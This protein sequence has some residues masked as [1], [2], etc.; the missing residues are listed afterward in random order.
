MNNALKGFMDSIKLKNTRTESILANIKKTITD[1][2]DSRGNIN[3]NIENLI[4]TGK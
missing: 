2:L 3:M 4:K 1:G